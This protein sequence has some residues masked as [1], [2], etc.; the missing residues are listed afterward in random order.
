MKT[1]E[2]AIEKIKVY[3]R[4]NRQLANQRAFCDGAIQAIG[5]VYDLPYWDIEEVIKEKE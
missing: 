1:L 5:W 4:T 3:Y 2:E